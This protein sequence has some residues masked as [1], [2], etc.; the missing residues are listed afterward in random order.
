MQG[1]TILAIYFGVFY[2]TQYSIFPSSWTSDTSGSSDSSG[3]SG[4]SDTS[5]S[6][7]SSGAS[8]GERK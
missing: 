7:G 2:K 5:G 1:F 4:S 6:N 8:A 3:S